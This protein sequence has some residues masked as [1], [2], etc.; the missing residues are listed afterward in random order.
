MGHVFVG[1]LSSQLYV[2]RDG[3]DTETLVDT[4]YFP[5]NP[6]HCMCDSMQEVAEDIDLLA[7]STCRIAN[8]N[9][10][11][12]QCTVE[13]S[14]LQSVTMNVSQCENPPKVTLTMVVAGNSYSAEVTGNRTETING[15]TVMITVWYYDYS[16]DLQV[17]VCD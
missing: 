2:D 15:I 17:C 11:Q 9:C 16:M 5:L 8:E 12:L 1:S 3:Q 13:Q 4:V 7:N 14:V 6:A 10:S